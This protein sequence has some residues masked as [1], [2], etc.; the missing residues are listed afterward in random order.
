MR[1]PIQVDPDSISWSIDRA[2]SIPERE[3][4]E[5][6]YRMLHTKLE[7]VGRRVIRSRASTCPPPVEIHPSTSSLPVRG[8]QPHRARGGRSTSVGRGSSILENTSIPSDA[9]TRAMDMTISESDD[10]ESILDA[11]S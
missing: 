7:A 11:S 3:E 9:T 6:V 1:R 10:E 8:P 4:E 5:E 2:P